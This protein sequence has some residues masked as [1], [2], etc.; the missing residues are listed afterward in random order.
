MVVYRPVAGVR[1]PVVSSSICSFLRAKS[2]V[3]ISHRSGSA[4][5]FC[6]TT[7]IRKPHLILAMRFTL[8]TM[9]EPG[10][11]AGGGNHISE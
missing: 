6:G 11:A 8:V 4:D 1:D 9:S 10:S 7:H 3:N 5:G 2:G